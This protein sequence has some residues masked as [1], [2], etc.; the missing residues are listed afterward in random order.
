MKRNY[1]SNL[2]F[3]ESG[4]RAC[5][6]NATDLLSATTVLLDARHF[7]VSLS[8]SVLAMEEIGKMMFI[9][10][11]L[12]A[13]SGD[14]KDEGFR[15]GFRKHPWKLRFLDLFPFFVHALAMVDLRYDEE[16][17]FRTAMAISLSN[18]KRERARLAE[19]LGAACDL[20]ELD[21]WKQQGLY[22]GTS[23][24]RFV[25]PNEVISEAFSRAA[26]GLARRFVT[27]VDFHLKNGGIDRYFA[28][29]KSIRSKLKETDHQIFEKLGAETFEEV[30]GIG[31]PDED[32]NP[33]Q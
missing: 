23:G 30:F 12:F 19:W 21:R 18:L 11:L 25:T 6:R 2:L 8:V 26:H 13:R 32:D 3:I 27:S 28:Q 5:W 15:S 7:G 29:A 33:T 9:D 17:R 14:H 1:R 4:F 10:G 22:A 20:T 16:Q 24:D 31:P